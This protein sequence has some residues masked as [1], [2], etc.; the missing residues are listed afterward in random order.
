LAAVL[1]FSPFHPPSSHS[2]YRHAF[3][4]RCVFFYLQAI[5]HTTTPST[6]AAACSTCCPFQL[7][8]H[9]VNHFIDIH[10]FTS[11]N[12][13]TSPTEFI[14][15]S[16]NRIEYV[17]YDITPTGNCLPN[18]NIPD[19]SWTS[20]LVSLWNDL[21]VGITSLPYLARYDSSKPYFLKTDWAGTGM[22]WILMQP[23]DSDS[24]A[25]ALALLR[26]DGICNFDVTMNGAHLCPIRFGSRGCTE[27]ERHYH[28]F[29]GEA[30][31][32]HWAI[33]QNREFLWGAEFFWLCDCSAIAE[34]LEY[35]G[36][37]HQIRQFLSS[38]PSP[39]AYDEG[40]QWPYLPL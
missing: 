4:L 39:C 12:A 22:G 1:L 35:D 9:F 15:R 32:G 8:A 18:P 13:A 36:P 23:D 30:G 11:I 38:L 5:P 2:P 27:R 20:S 7:G 34:I 16:L 17:S 25:A 3:H 33:S 14:T 24:S 37:I 31:Y 10:L 19:V 28:S 21:K 29:A 6:Y 40:C 26:S